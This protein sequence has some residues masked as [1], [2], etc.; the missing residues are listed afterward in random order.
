MESVYET[1]AAAAAAA[2]GAGETAESLNLTYGARLYNAMEPLR[3]NLGELI[4]RMQS[5]SDDLGHDPGLHLMVLLT[6]RRDEVL[7]ERALSAVNPRR[8]ML[9][10]AAAQAET[11]RSLLS[12]SFTN[13]TWRAAVE[14]EAE[15]S[16]R[17][18]CARSPEKA[19]WLVPL[20]QVDASRVK[21]EVQ[22]LWSAALFCAL[23]EVNTVVKKWR[24]QNAMMNYDE[25]IIAAMEALGQDPPEGFTAQFD[26]A[27][28]EAVFRERYPDFAPVF[29][30]GSDW[31]P[32]GFP[33]YR[34]RWVSVMEIRVAA[35][36]EPARRAFVLHRA[37][38]LYARGRESWL[39]RMVRL[40]RVAPPVG[41]YI[42]TAHPRRQHTI[43][44]ED[45]F[46]YAG[47]WGAA[48]RCGGRYHHLGHFS[49]EHAAS[50]AY[51]A[52]EQR[53]VVDLGPSTLVTAEECLC[54]AAAFE[55]CLREEV[56]AHDRS[57][58]RQ[59][60]GVAWDLPSEVITHN[61]QIETVPTKVELE[62]LRGALQFAD[63]ST[64]SRAVTVGRCRFFP[65]SGF[66]AQAPWADGLAAEPVALEF[67]KTA[68]PTSHSLGDGYVD[69]AAEQGFVQN[70]ELPMA[71][72]I[73]EDRARRCSL[74]YSAFEL[75][76]V[77]PARW[78]GFGV[79]E[80]QLSRL[81]RLVELETLHYPTLAAADR[82]VASK[83]PL[84]AGHEVGRAGIDG[85]ES[86]FPG[87]YSGSRALQP[88]TDGGASLESA[89][90]L[91]PFSP[92]WTDRPGSDGPGFHARGYDRARN[93]EY[94][95]REEWRRGCDE[96]RVRQL[97]NGPADSLLTC[98]EGP[99]VVDAA[100]DVGQE[101]ALLDSPTRWDELA[102]S[103]VY[104]WQEGDPTDEDMSGSAVAYREAS[105][106]YKRPPLCATVL[107]TAP[108]ELGVRIE[109][110]DVKKGFANAVTRPLMSSGIHCVSFVL[111]RIDCHL[112]QSAS[113]RTDV[114]SDELPNVYA[115][116]ELQQTTRGSYF[117]GVC[118]ALPPE[119][120]AREP[121]RF[122]RT[123]DGV[124]GFRPFTT[125][126]MEGSQSEERTLAR[127]FGWQDEFGFGWGEETSPFTIANADLLKPVV[128]DTVVLVLDATAGSLAVFRENEDGEDGEDGE[129]PAVQLDRGRAPRKARQMQMVA[130]VTYLGD[131]AHSVRSPGSRGQSRERTFA[132]TNFIYDPGTAG[133]RVP[134]AALHGPWQWHVSLQEMFSSCEVTTREVTQEM[135][136]D[137]RQSAAKV[138]NC[139]S[140]LLS[141]WDTAGPH[142]EYDEVRKFIGLGRAPPVKNAVGAG[143]HDMRGLARFFASPPLTHTLTP[144][145]DVDDAYVSKAMRAMLGIAEIRGS[146]LSVLEKRLRL[147]AA[148]EAQIAEFF[149]A[150]D[151]KAYA[152]ELIWLLEGPGGALGA[153]PTDDDLVTFADFC[154]WY[155]LLPVA[156]VTVDPA[157]PNEDLDYALQTA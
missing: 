22:E 27:S 87:E 28:G 21:R 139:E 40:E 20:E 149:E 134:S 2:A 101:T 137:M 54:R 37:I 35:L 98:S 132:P 133:F 88:P 95:A 106:S 150:E 8:R 42:D 11:F 143:L 74:E 67:L 76:D 78:C 41:A 39:R 73:A 68:G 84:A 15:G 89:F 94:L 25:A 111:R 126:P 82:D 124:F 29:R 145:N 107:L 81:F 157:K 102:A 86:K 116:G 47:R 50:E 154:E 62:V 77:A 48:I 121:F 110:E 125:L 138:R 33:L 113:T 123:D 3:P 109:G 26:E 97:R 151:S 71:R 99:R 136:E 146:E 49:T 127:A 130:P 70:L 117:V 93:L 53:A 152:V 131:F 7:L 115:D 153:A 61:L 156:D 14:D 148:S 57:T 92:P 13:R 141:A 23:S 118:R 10:S 75:L 66:A 96:F 112:L 12:I 90:A 144:T 85:D 100:N 1:D 46:V 105:G 119:S 34:G 43:G 9:E 65:G 30:E 52:A 58:L 140:G 91:V 56:E 4:A 5:L 104:G 55:A 83:P 36:N 31:I 155:A 45:A 103:E 142:G 69:N 17:L 80:S 147:R 16:L 44:P 59:A 108:I 24:R 128:G 60:D 63:A 18:C 64:E 51:R 6:E 38:V 122:P 135:H 32:G 114:D 72:G 120:R 129:D 19:S 79:K